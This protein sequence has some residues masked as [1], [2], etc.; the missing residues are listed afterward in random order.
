MKL[1]VSFREPHNHSSDLIMGTCSESPLTQDRD[2]RELCL[3]PRHSRHTF[4][5]PP[6]PLSFPPSDLL[7]LEAATVFIFRSSASSHRNISLAGAELLQVLFTALSPAGRKA[8]FG[9][10]PLTNKY[11][12]DEY[13]AR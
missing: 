8:A 7:S 3:P 4:I 1:N 9:S 13:T 6:P 2:I 5:C 12:L 11:L 10:A